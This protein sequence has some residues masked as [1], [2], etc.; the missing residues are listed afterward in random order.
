M[1]PELRNEL[2]AKAMVGRYR[3]GYIQL[4]LL[5]A[6][7]LFESIINYKLKKYDSCEIWTDARIDDTRLNDKIKRVGEIPSAIWDDSLYIRRLRPLFR[8]FRSNNEKDKLLR[9]SDDDQQR[10]THVKNRLYNF[11]WLRNQVMH[12]KFSK[13]KC[14]NDKLIDDMIVYVWSELASGHFKSY[15]LIWEGECSDG[16]IVDAVKKHSADYMIR[17]IDEVDIRSIDDG[18]PAATSDWSVSLADLSNL[19]DVR[20]K[21]IALK[22]YLPQWLKTNANHLHTNTLTT[23]D[24]ASAYIWMPLTRIDNENQQGIIS[25]TVSILATPMDLRIYMDFGGMAVNYR[26][27]YYDFLS[28]DACRDISLAFI[29]NPNFYVFDTEW[30]CFITK[31]RNMCSWLTDD[32]E[33]DIDAAQNE[34]GKYFESI[35]DQITWNRMLHGYIFDRDY[36]SK[37]GSISLEQIELCLGDII[38]FNNIFEEFRSQRDK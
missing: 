34:A 38:K 33:K 27:E 25:C 28:S 11:L 26:R 3:L 10:L 17:G 9:M 23:I 31:K 22:N 18:A 15:L 5:I 20:D 37:H 30:Y 32:R 2:L 8:S 29:S 1:T 21:L 24:T 4:S 14:E 36:F 35:S 7:T 19:F 6:G 13:V 16:R 12:G